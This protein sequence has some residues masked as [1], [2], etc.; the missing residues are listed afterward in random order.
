MGRPFATK[1]NAVAE[2]LSAAAV[3]EGIAKLCVIQR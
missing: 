2:Q 1:V 3:A